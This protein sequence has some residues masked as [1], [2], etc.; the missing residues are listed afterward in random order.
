MT[1]QASIIVSAQVAS[2]AVVQQEI[3]R[4]VRILDSPFLP[5]FQRERTCREIEANIRKIAMLREIHES[6]KVA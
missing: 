5:R 4:L 3:Q 1:E 6:N 2:V